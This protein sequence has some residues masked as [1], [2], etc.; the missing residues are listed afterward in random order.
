MMISNWT[1][2]TMNSIYV[3]DFVGEVVVIINKYP[4]I[5]G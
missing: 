3:N 4:E 2:Y 5:S 1:F